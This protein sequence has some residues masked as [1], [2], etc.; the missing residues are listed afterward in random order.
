MKM[1]SIS[2]TAA[3]PVESHWFL[4]ERSEY[5]DS[6]R[7]LNVN[8]SPF[9]IGR[10][11]NLALCLP[12][13]S[14]SK[15]HAELI[16]DDSRLVV[17]DLGST[18]GTFVNG[19]RIATPTP[20]A[21]GDLLQFANAVFRVGHQQVVF[22]PRTVEES[23]ADWAEALCQFDQLMSE[24]SVVPHFQ[25]IVDL[26]DSR[27]VGFE[28]LGRSRIKGLELPR[29]MFAA[30]ERLDQECALSEMLRTEGLQ[31]GAKLLARPSLFVNTHP[32]EILAPRF[33]ESI[34]ELRRRFPSQ[35]LV[36]EI[37]EAAVTDIQALVDFRALLRELRMQL[38][39]DDFGAGQARLLE[40]TETSPDY[41]KFDMELIRGI[42]SATPA[43]K[44]T[45]AALV[46]MVADLKIATLAEGI[47]TGEEA[48][49]CRALGFDLAQGFYFGHPAPL[50]ET[51][52]RS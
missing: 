44:Q 33:L 36:I 37:H 4:C 12:G 27:T 41:V 16:L 34:K 21:D 13:G 5:D 10:L 28:V 40:L 17:R 11:P 20:L 46:R 48:A 8:V 32:S 35:A 38:A 26:A 52:E 29:L 23:A 2:S 31:S 1:E 49:A 25:P 47:E 7:W 19:Q 15:L 39:F 18:N 51:I 42:D 6:V 9:R 43:R 50:A 45:L 14:V 3:T 30:A 22:C 24:R